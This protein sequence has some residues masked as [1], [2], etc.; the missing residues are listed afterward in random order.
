MVEIDFS[1]IEEKYS[2][3]VP[4]GFN[5]VILI[6]NLPIVDSKKEEKLINVI[7]KIFKDITQEMSVFMPMKSD[8]K[9]KG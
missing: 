2:I 4:E 9:S 5:N 6:D 3:T 1:D 7:K 8:E